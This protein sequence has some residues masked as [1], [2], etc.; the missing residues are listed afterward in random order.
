MSEATL[1][2]LRCRNVDYIVTK[3]GP[4]NSF[5]LPGVAFGPLDKIYLPSEAYVEIGSVAN[6]TLHW[7]RILTNNTGATKLRN[8]L[9]ERFQINSVDYVRKMI[10]EDKITCPSL[11]CAL[12][13]YN[14]RPELHNWSCGKYLEWTGVDFVLRD[15][16]TWS[17]MVFWGLISCFSN[18][19]APS[20]RAR[21]K[22]RAIEDIPAGIY[23]EDVIIR[24]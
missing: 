15:T 11:I 13:F 2:F 21:P 22:L 14:E 23:I 20:I 17:E 7:T 8:Y 9:S 16:Q 12:W 5:D 1:I 10:L 24:D 4:N 6:V 3:I 18:R 19:R